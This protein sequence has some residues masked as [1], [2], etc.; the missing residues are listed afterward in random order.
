MAQGALADFV[1]EYEEAKKAFDPTTV[2]ITFLLQL[3]PEVRAEL[4]SQYK[5]DIM[6]SVID[7]V[8]TPSELPAVPMDLSTVAFCEDSLW[9]HVTV[10]KTVYTDACFR[11]VPLEYFLY[12]AT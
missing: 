12:V 6:Q 11:R 1:D 5:N 7:R 9:S 8:C 10:K 3:A 2:D 4:L